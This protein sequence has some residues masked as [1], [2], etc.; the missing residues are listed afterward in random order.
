M[1]FWRAYMIKKIILTHILMFFS[2]FCYAQTNFDRGQELFMQNEPAQAV[3]F[4][5]RALAEDPANTVVYLYLGVVY[6]QLGRAD[7]A[8]AIYRRILP[9]AGNLSANVANNLGNVYF[10]RD[11]NEEA[12]R[13]FSQ[14]VSF[15]PLYPQAFL[16][17]ANTRM[18]SGNLQSAILDY[19]QYLM[20]AP[21]ARQRVFIEQLIAL[22]RAEI[23][24]EEM[25][26]MIA[27]EEERRLAEERQKLLDSVSASLQSAADT[28]RGISVGAEG[29]LHYDGEFE[30]E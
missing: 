20:L 15:D 2:L 11:N 18:R 9:M 4:L 28:S 24:A 29:L 1:D 30:L 14:A 6:E 5:E 25:R 22:V 26:R 19:E 23:A 12:E 3:V 7:D 17:R 13:F 8:I 21:N 27:A 16:G 10:K